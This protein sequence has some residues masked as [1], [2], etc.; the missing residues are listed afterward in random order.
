MDKVVV[1][2]DLRQMNV[3]RQWLDQ[4]I[5]DGGYLVATPEE[6]DGAFITPAHP[7]T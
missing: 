7:H 6:A 3:G 4:T 2:R 1:Y 5:A